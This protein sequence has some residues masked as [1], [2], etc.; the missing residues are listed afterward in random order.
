MC[1]VVLQCVVLR[2]VLCCVACIVSTCVQC[3]CLKSV[4]LLRWNEIGQESLLWEPVALK[5]AYERFQWKN[6]DQI[7]EK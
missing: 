5:L 7:R 4:A 3:G 2:S 1:C 6:L